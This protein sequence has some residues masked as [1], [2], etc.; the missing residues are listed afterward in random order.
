MTGTELAAAQL[1]R[2]DGSHAPIARG[3]GVLAGTNMVRPV[4][5]LTLGGAALWPESSRL[6]PAHPAVTSRPSMFMPCDRDDRA[7]H[8]RMLTLID[9]ALAD[10][11]RAAAAT[12]RTRHTTTGGHGGKPWRLGSSRRAEWRL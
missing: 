2:P 9:A 12:R 11:K 3:R 10:V 1:P 7:T 8:E 5:P 4:Q 6:S